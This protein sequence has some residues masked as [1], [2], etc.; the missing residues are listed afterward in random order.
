M[1]NLMQLTGF[2]GATMLALAG[3]GGDDGGSKET[4]SPKVVKAITAAE[5][6][7]V[8]NGNAALNIPAGA[9]PEDTEVSIEEVSTKGLGSGATVVGEAWNLGPEGLTFLEPVTL[10]LTAPSIPAGKDV[11]IAYL[12]E[13][14]D[15]W[16]PL[17]NQDVNGKTISGDTMHFSTFALVFVDGEQV[18][19]GCEGAF[20]ACGGD[21]VGEWTVTEGCANVDVADIFGDGENP[22]ASCEGAEIAF[23]ADVVGTITFNQDETYT[24]A[25]GF[26]TTITFDVPKS[27]LGGACPTDDEDSPWTESGD[28]CE[29]QEVDDDEPST[30]TGT[31]AV[32]GDSF[33]FANDEADGGTSDGPESFKFCVE[34]DT[35]HVQAFFND[36]ASEVRFTATR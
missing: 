24:S 11:V 21:I 22:F 27:C 23:D 35:M 31:Y 17:A 10:A 16:E 1:R 25:I 2:V 12:N 20:E 9:L 3:C 28:R 4:L 6:G 30:D 26:N 34:G 5:G 15:K 8:E 29:N 33:T 7:T 18:A 13:T 14:T 36:G 32:D 19:G